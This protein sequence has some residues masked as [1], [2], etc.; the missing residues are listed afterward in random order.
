MTALS[1]GCVLL[2]AASDFYDEGD[3]IRNH[4]EFLRW[5]AEHDPV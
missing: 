3:Y 2:I 4:D 1:T 5:L